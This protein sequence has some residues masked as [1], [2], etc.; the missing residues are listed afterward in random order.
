MISICAKCVCMGCGACLNACPHGCISMMEDPEGFLFPV[1][2]QGRC[3]DCG[4]C[5]RMC[6]MAHTSPLHPRSKS[7]LAAWNH[8]DGIRQRSSSGGVFIQ[9]AKEV[10]SHGGVVNIV[11]FDDEFS[12]HHVLVDNVSEVLDVQGSKYVQS[13]TG[14]VYHDVRVALSDGKEVLFVS[15]PCQIAGLKAFLGR[16]YDGL[17]T[18]DF[19]CHG[20]PSP[21]YFRKYVRQRIKSLCIDG[22]SDYIFRNLRAWGWRCAIQTRGGGCID[23]DSQ[24]DPYMGSFLSGLNYRECCYNC[25]FATERRCSDLTI[26]D[27]WSVKDFGLLTRKYEKGTS[28]LLINTMKGRGMLSRISSCLD[29]NEFPWFATAANR[30]LY[31]PAARPKARE[32]FYKVAIGGETFEE[33][34]RLCGISD[35]PRRHFECFRAIVR[36]V[37]LEL[38]R[39]VGLLRIL[40]WNLHQEIMRCFYE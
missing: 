25:K 14:R 10:L 37:R 27:F 39:T 26:G 24:S 1:I 38:K 29:L 5:S 36:S 19:I 23:F 34:K 40:S 35:L 3:S 15:T 2:D 17:V 9:L 16:E 7:V 12:L 20:V 22:A 30:Q 31:M 33:V 21:G 32:C 13:D 11:R 8:D 28:L 6:K 4:I 18:C